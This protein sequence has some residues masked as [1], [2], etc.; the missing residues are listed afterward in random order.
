MPQTVPILLPVVAGLAT[1]LLGI[2]ALRL[3]A[4]LALLLAAAVTAALSVATPAAVPVPARVAAAF[5]DTVGKIGLLIAFAAVLGKCLLDSGA[6]ERIVRSTLNIG[7]ERS[8]PVAFAG[9][10][11]LLGI[12]VFFDTVF[13]LLI[14]L[15]KAVRLRTGRNYVLYV[16]AIFAGATMAHSLVPPTPGPLL[17]AE[18]LGVSIGMMIGVGLAV[19]LVCV[20]YG[21]L[22]AVVVN[23]LI[24]VPLRESPDMPLAD[25]ERLAATPDA[26]LPPLWASVIP[27]LLPVL[28]IGLHETTRLLGG[29][30]WFL[31]ST[32]VLGEK[33]VAVAA[34]MIAGL[35]LLAW[36]TR[37][38]VRSLRAA[39]QDALSGGGTVILVTAAGGTFGA[40]LADTGIAQ[41]IGNLPAL[42]TAG[43]VTA[44]FVVTAIIR[45]A[46]GSATV[47]MMTAVGL[48]TGV[49]L[50]FHP[51]WLAVAIGCGSKPVSWMTDSGF[52]IVGRIAGFTEAETLKTVTPLTGM[53]GVVGWATTLAGAL[54]FPMT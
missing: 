3:H 6:A 39:V 27:I 41:L 7:G 25:L 36:R 11:F 2:L 35:L 19:G 33:N 46:Q 42:G 49:A 8:A 45:T 16:L 10:A 18:K 5:G 9:S 54:L 44:A 14:P 48:F 4:F 24:D 20:V 13:L 30:D 1:V 43:L 31:K 28:L 23:R 17:V 47:A 53:M 21:L 51:V 52:W 50:P 40:M 12:P 29:P 26:D 15:G 22:H 38:T 37:G 34:G 32:A